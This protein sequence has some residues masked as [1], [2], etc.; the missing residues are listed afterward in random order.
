MRPPNVLSFTKIPQNVCCCEIHENIRACVKALKKSGPLF[1]FLN[2]DYNIH[3]NFTCDQ[4]TIKCFDNKCANCCSSKHLKSVVEKLENPSQL[5]TWFKWVKTSKSDNQ[6]RQTN[7]YCNVE[8]VEKSGHLHELLDETI[9]LVPHFLE[10]Q[11]VK[12]NQSNANKRMIERALKLNSE[13]AVIVCDFAENFK[14]LQQNST[15]SAHYGQTPVTLFT[16]AVYHRKLLPLTIASNCEKHTKDSIFAYLDKLL[17][18]LPD[19]VKI[20][21]FWSDNATSQF[22]NQYNLEAMKKF[23]FRYPSFQIKWNFYAPMHG[24]SVVDGIGGSVK[25]FVRSRI[26]AQNLIVKS[27]EDFVSI[28]KEMDIKVILMKNSDIEQC[29]IELGLKQIVKDSKKIQEIKKKHFFSVE[30]LTVGKKNS[31]KIVGLRITPNAA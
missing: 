28:A 11:Y 8:K 2:S 22:K 26:V 5:V 25:R 20:V 19:T 1:H 24:K 23:E 18:F 17:Q 12:L 9:S 3:K 27:A 4:P 13:H 29:N 21:D 31:G 30:T 10:H 7:V 15:Q 14:C 6:D 16:V